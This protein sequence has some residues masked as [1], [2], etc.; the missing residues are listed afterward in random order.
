LHGVERHVA[1]YGEIVCGVADA[2]S[3]LSLVITTSSLQ[4]KR[5]PICQWLR[6]TVFNRSGD[7]AWMSR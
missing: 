6:R 5:L 3:V 1:E 7:N 4:C 2:G